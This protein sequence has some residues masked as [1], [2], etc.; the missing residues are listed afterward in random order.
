MAAGAEIDAPTLFISLHYVT[1]HGDDCR[2]LASESSVSTVCAR[3]A[4]CQ[5][6][7]AHSTTYPSGC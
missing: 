1:Y 2:K 6:Y 5:F 3:N 4:R 7:E